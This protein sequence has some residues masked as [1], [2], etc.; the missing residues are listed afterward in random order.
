MT[1][2]RNRPDRSARSAL[3]ARSRAARWLWLAACWLWLAAWSPSPAA[4]LDGGSGPDAD[5]YAADPDA[6]DPPPPEEFEE[7]EAL[8]RLEQQLFP[9]VYQDLQRLERGLGVPTGPDPLA[10]SPLSRLHDASASLAA[11]S[12]PA[13]GFMAAILDTRRDLDALRGKLPSLR[14]PFGLPVLDDPAVQEAL[15]FFTRPGSSTLRVWLQRAAQWRPIILPILADEG[16][17]AELFYLAMIESGLKNRARSPANAA[18]M[19]Q[20]I[21]STAV[22]QGLRID[23]FVDERLDPI[24]STRAAARYLKKQH[25]RF[26]SWPLAMAA[27]NG[28]S[29]TVASAIERYNAND[30][31]KLVAY[32]AMYDE[33]RRYVPKIIA[34]ALLSQHPEA[35]GFD[36]L[37]PLPPFAFDEVDAPPDARLSLLAQ[38]AGCSIDALRAL[39]PELLLDQ[40]P[41]GAPYPL[42]IPPGAFSQFT[43]QWEDLTQRY[44]DAHERYVVRFGE[45]VE[46][47]AAQV[48]LP[49]RV[50]RQ[51]NG[52]PPKRNPPYLTPILLPTQGRAASG[53]S[54][55][56]SE[57]PVALV[58]NAAFDP[59][60]TRRVFYRVNPQD[61]LQHI[62]RHFRLSPHQVA[63]WNDLDP[64]AYLRGG[65]TL[66]LFL[67]PD[68]DLSQTVVLPPDT[69]A[70]LVGSPEHKALTGSKPASG[71]SGGGGGGGNARAYRVQAGDTVGALAKRF[72]ISARDIIRWNNLDKDAVIRPGMRL[73]IH[74]ASGKKPDPKKPEPQKPSAQKPEP[75]KPE[76][77]KP[78]PKAAAAKPTPAK[79]APSPAKPTATKPEPQKPDPKKPA[80]K[81][82]APK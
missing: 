32:G 75:K 48:G 29:G 18:G 20:F 80:P 64:T 79:A 52:I 16:V 63:V 34:A 62:A 6:D 45:T 25:A 78:D 27:Y 67:P 54:L 77:Q 46:M 76:P 31:F 17:P 43:T 59:P 82:P 68:F 4:A 1:A 73:V 38:A 28:G 69:R 74:S 53:A 8:R 47:V 40:T 55:G 42:R 12:A 15:A 3:P 7:L 2:H 66:Q 23:A 5:P 37:T 58:P 71:G 60:N 19:W 51:V 44:G 35:F 61:S 9:S 56:A 14:L 81:K 10:L 30:Y 65:M 72:N 57:P 33:T 24:K 22:D 41:P 13:S 36:G 21:P 26:G 11:S 39:N 70:V 50:I 49:A